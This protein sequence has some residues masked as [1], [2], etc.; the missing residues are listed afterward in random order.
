M[1]NTDS[2]Y[3]ILLYK[4]LVQK[5]IYI[6][7]LNDIS[8]GWNYLDK[9]EDL[10]NDEE[11]SIE[12]KY[13]EYTKGYIKKND[14]L[15]IDYDWIYYYIYIILFIDGNLDLY[16]S[17]VVKLIHDSDFLDEDKKEKIKL[18]MIDCGK[19][20]DVLN[21]WMEGYIIELIVYMIDLDMEKEF[22]KITTDLQ[23][24][25]LESYRGIINYFIDYIG[26]DNNDKTL[27][28]YLGILRQESIKSI[29]VGKYQLI[30]KC[31][32][33]PDEIKLE[34]KYND[35][36]YTSVIEEK[37]YDVHYLEELANYFNWLSKSGLCEKKFQIIEK[38]IEHPRHL[39]RLVLCLQDSYEFDF[40]K[41][42]K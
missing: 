23:N 1:S 40:I 30:V 35:F 17:I 42:D 7:K 12:N 16:E 8:E 32:H 10:Q 2:A 26:L 34:I 28:K 3:F 25:P 41:S 11:L 24:S 19:T 31:Y 9:M 36:K 13:L 22:K 6:P 33:Y 14:T 27:N 29:L 38:R 4:Y 37:K 18:I 5:N 39:D 15:Q 20:P 21:G